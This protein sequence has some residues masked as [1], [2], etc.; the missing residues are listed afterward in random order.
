LILGLFV[1]LAGVA[2]ALFTVNLWLGIYN[3]RQ[4]DP[5]E[6]SWS[7]MF[8]IFLCGSF[9]VLA[10]GRALGADAWIRPHLASVKEGRGVGAPLRLGTEP[11]GRRWVNRPGQERHSSRRLAPTSSRGGSVAKA[12]EPQ[13]A[14]RHLGRNGHRRQ[15]QSRRDRH[16]LARVS[17]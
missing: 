2:A 15:L 7:Y 1:R 17:K 13:G 9:A 16:V 6:W 10:A 12:G 14:A 11:A 8:L 4:G 3:K 5:D